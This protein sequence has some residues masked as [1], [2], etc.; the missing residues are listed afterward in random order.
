MKHEFRVLIG[1]AKQNAVGYRH[2]YVEARR[3]LKCRETA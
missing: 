3:I 1:I 2:L